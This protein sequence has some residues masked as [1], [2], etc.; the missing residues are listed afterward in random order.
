M[1]R[2]AFALLVGCS[3][4][5]S[6]LDQTFPSAAPLLSAQA[7]NDRSPLL[8]L[9]E[10][11]YYPDVIK[12]VE[13]ALENFS[14]DLVREGGCFNVA[15]RDAMAVPFLRAVDAIG[16]LP[17][18]YVQAVGSGTGA[19]AAMESIKRIASHRG[20]PAATRLLL[21]QNAPFTPIVDAWQLRD[22]QLPRFE[23]DYVR[24]RVSSIRAQVLSNASPP[25]AVKGGVFDILAESNGVACAVDNDEIE[26]AQR[27]AERELEF[28]PC[29]ASSAALAGLKKSIA[30][31][32]V[33]KDDLILLHLTGGGFEELAAVE[34]AHPYSNRV[35][36]NHSDTETFYGAI[37][38][39]IGRV[40]NK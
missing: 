3:A 6:R 24:D 40:R 12:F 18:W 5:K 16:K 15:R 4:A 2:A 26:A 11:A 39:Y 36:A 14:T 35:L 8:L 31:G 25:Y 17:D 28:V 10:D 32:D 22:R 19:V 27:L 38:A 30:R 33:S 9:L 21:V 37:S 34:G 29:D 23:P 7:R 20:E 1:L 13:G